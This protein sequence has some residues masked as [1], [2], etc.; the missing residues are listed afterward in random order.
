MS[1]PTARSNGPSPSWFQSWPSPSPTAVHALASR[2][3]RGA[4]FAAPY[5]RI[6]YSKLFR[7]FIEALGDAAAN[8][9]IFVTN[10]ARLYGFSSRSGE[11][12]H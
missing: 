12:A 7:D 2:D 8:E 10:P 1:S 11:N 9:R 6:E 3:Q 5:R 4:T